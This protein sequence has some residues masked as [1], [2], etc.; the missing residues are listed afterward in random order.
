MGAERFER[1]RAPRWA[2][3]IVAVVWTVAVGSVIGGIVLLIVPNGP[4]P[5]HGFGSPTGD[6]LVGLAYAAGVTV[7][8]LIVLR[9]PELPL[10]WI[11]LAAGFFTATAS[12]VSEYYSLARDFDLPGAAVTAWYGAWSWELGAGLALSFALLLFPTGRLPSRRWLVAAWFSALMLLALT[13]GQALAPGRFSGEFQL[14]RNPYGVESARWLR[15]WRDFAWGFQLIITSVS[16]AALLTRF[17]RAGAVER[18]QLKWFAYAVALNA[19][20]LTL[21]SAAVDHGRVWAQGLLV[22][23]VVSFPVAFGV[24]VLRYR[25]FDI[26]RLVSRTVSYS[27][28]TLL[29]GAVYTAAALLAGRAL[30][31]LEE[32][33]NL[34]VAM[35]TLAA[36]AVFRPARMRIQVAV[37]RRFNRSRFDGARTLAAFRDRLRGEQDLEGVVTSLVESVNTTL[38]PTAAS[39]WLPERPPSAR[40]HDR[41]GVMAP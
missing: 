6:G 10:G 14:M 23:A 7:G 3:A 11:M 2:V 25:L 40:I 18:A 22:L 8:A 16:A 36:A 41:S 31:P 17:R 9:R 13:L 21:R 19:V 1:I 30:A 28:L 39:V 37:D 5:P 32:G 38:Q 26:Q 24:A 29:L 15:D 34:A 12:G 35:A 33:S 20:A 27:L 4:M